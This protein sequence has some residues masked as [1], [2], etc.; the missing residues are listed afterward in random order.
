MRLTLVA[1]HLDHPPDD[2]LATLGAA[3][4]EEDVEVVLTI[5]P[6]VELVEDAVG[7]GAEA[8]G[9]HEAR[10]VKEL[11]VRVDNLGFWFK[12]I[13]TTRTGD[14]LQVHDARH[15]VEEVGALGSRAL[16]GAMRRQAALGQCVGTALLLLSRC[17]ALHCLVVARHAYLARLARNSSSPAATSSSLRTGIAVTGHAGTGPSMGPGHL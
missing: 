5:L 14:A 15:P 10:A 12:A 2:E 1:T 9:T 3:W 6:A 16:G 11:P 13:V 7:E 17:A 4:R 8:L